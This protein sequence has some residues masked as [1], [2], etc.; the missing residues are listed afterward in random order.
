M[1]SFTKIM[2]KNRNQKFYLRINIFGT[3]KF[4]ADCDKTVSVGTEDLTTLPSFPT[5]HFPLPS[6]PSANWWRNLPLR[7]DSA[8][9]IVRVSFHS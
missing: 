8:D 6:F 4:V 5:E 2:G 9:G 1:C 3:S 7:S